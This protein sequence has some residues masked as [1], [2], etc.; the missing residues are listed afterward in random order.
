MCLGF[1][2]VSNRAGVEACGAETKGHVLNHWAT[3]SLLELGGRGGG[4]VPGTGIG[5]HVYPPAAHAVLCSISYSWPPSLF[6]ETIL[7]GN[8]YRAS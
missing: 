7:Y 4:G 1:R 3:S 2:P 8:D 6:R 5:V